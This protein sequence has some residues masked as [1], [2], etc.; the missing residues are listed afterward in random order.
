MELFD[1]FENKTGTG[2][3]AT[4]DQNGQVNAAIYSRPHIFEDGTAGFIMRDRLTHANLQTNGSAA[5]LF[6]EDGGGYNGRR[7]YL[8]KISE[9]EDTERLSA[10][11]RRHLPPESEAAKGPPYLVI[12]KVTKVLPLIGDGGQ[13]D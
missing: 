13:E 1:Y 12:F 9:E 6:R 3:L 10:L 8:S 5:Y 2:I 4:A 11:K 7:L